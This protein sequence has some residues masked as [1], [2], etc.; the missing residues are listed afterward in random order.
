MRTQKE[1]IR[2]VKQAKKLYKRG[3]KTLGE[4]LDSL[5]LPAAT[6]YRYTKP[7]K[8]TKRRN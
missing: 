7:A 3:N 8:K 5:D 2:D 6:Y 1:S 4:I